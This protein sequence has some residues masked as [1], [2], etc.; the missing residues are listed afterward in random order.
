TKGVV[1]V[2][3]G[4][5]LFT[6]LHYR[7][8]A[9]PILAPVNGPGGVKMTRQWPMGDA[10]PGEATDHPHHK[11]LWFTHGAVNGTDFWAESEKTGKI[12]VSGK[13]AIK[14][15]SGEVT[16]E[17]SEDWKAPDG[18]RVCQ[19]ATSIRCGT[20]GADRTIDYT[21]TIKASEGDVTF[22]DTKEGTM[23]IRSNPVLNLKGT[24]AA[25][26]ALNSEGLKDEAIWGKAARWV[27]YTA[28]V[29]GKVTGIACFDHP[30]NLRH[31]TTWHARE[32]GLIAANPFG[33]HDFEKKPKGTGDYVIKKGESLTLRYRWLFHTGDTGAAK[34]EE[35]WKK[36]AGK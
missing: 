33:L 29:E 1:T 22:G 30:S 13:P 6:E 14:A 16:I 15:G 28:P 27:D 25:G 9:K 36:W 31:P 32:Y 21:I 11:G 8:Y 23:G 20:D 24:G 7:E 18:K 12:V 2:R 34:I 26:H 17:T 5:E 35:R 3:I 10:L 4:N 19:S